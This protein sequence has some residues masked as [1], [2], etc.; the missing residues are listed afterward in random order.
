MAGFDN[1]PLRGPLATRQ[2]GAHWHYQVYGKRLC[3]GLPMPVLPRSSFGTSDVAFRYLS[4]G[5]ASDLA[6]EDAC[7][8][9]RRNTNLG[10]HLSLYRN[11]SGFVLRWEGQ[12]DFLIDKNGRQI[13]CST[14]PDT[15]VMWVLGVLFSMVLP[16][17]LF[18][19]G[20]GNF[21]SSS[22]VLPQGAVGFMAAPG[23]GK[24]TLAAGFAESGYPFLTDDVLA[25][26]E[27]AGQLY[28]YPGFP[29]VAISSQAVDCLFGRREELPVV[30]HNGEKQ[31]V[32]IAD[33]GVDFSIH[34]APLKALFILRRGCPVTDIRLELLPRVSAVR[35][36]LEHTN[37]LSLLP[38]EVLQPH[39]AFIG[40]MTSTL[41]VYRL[42]YPSGLAHVPQVIAAVAEEVQKLPDPVDQHSDS[43]YGGKADN[44]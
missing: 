17:A 25:V 8:L 29:H 31:R 35:G 11:E 6:R 22:V 33:L 2:N 20:V 12:C 34:P 40:H 36:L 21:H 28:G 44:Q 4:P 3:S 39:M 1:I 23:S 42:H 18:L 38:Q 16:F 19:S 26:Q 15:D 27:D 9:I 7:L 14:S 43:V 41:P 10:C 37:C 30:F 24:S 32:A 13:Q 5:D